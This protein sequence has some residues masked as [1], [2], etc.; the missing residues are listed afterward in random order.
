M[1]YFQ[2]GHQ[3]LNLGTPDYELLVPQLW[4]FA[5]LTFMFLAQPG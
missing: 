2:V 5:K 3:N 1:L 4:K